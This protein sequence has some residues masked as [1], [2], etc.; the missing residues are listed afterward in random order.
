MTTNPARRT[1]FAATIT[2]VL[3]VLLA[4]NVSVLVLSQQTQREAKKLA[5]T[6]ADCQSENGAC[7]TRS[8]QRVAAFIEQMERSNLYLV[9]CSKVTNTDDELQACLDQRRADARNPAGPSPTPSSPA[10]PTVSPEPTPST[11]QDDDETP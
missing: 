6:V 8:Q 7:Y 3:F 1:L 10:S 9:Q 2:A 4:L 5:A 11:A